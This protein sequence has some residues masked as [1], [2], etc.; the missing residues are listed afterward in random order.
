MLKD[1]KGGT[2]YDLAFYSNT[3]TRKFQ[4]DLLV[5][6]HEDLY[7]S[8]FWRNKYVESRIHNRD[9]ISFRKVDFGEGEY[10]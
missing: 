9:E 7:Q 4:W 1:K 5:L 3:K 2:G 8:I 10:E 6:V